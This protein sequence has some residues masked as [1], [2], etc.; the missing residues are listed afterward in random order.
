MELRHLT[1]FV[2]VAEE[3]HFGRAAERLHIAQSPLS[4]Q[5][6][7]LERDLGVR[8]FERTTRTVR[9]T[10]AGQALVEPARR[11]LADA[12]AVRRTVRA[13]HLGEAGRVT[14]GFAGASSYSALPL[15][16]RA[17]TSRLPGIELVLEGRTY[18]GEALRRIIDGTL[19]IGFV[20]LPVRRG[21]TAR[22]V[23]MERLVLALPDSHP[24][25]GRPGVPVSELADEPIVTFPLSRESAVREA[26]VQACHDAGFAPRIAQEAPDSYTMLALVG[27]GVGVAVVV[28]S[29]RDIHLEHVVFRPL[30]GDEVP[31]LPM[32]L[33]WRTGDRSA[34]LEAVLRVA[35]E[36]LPTPA[37]APDHDG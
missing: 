37:D 11:L 32:A 24:L 31:V 2:A 29:A 23:R 7:L 28:E 10:P 12:S 8:L 3:L 34:A 20:A 4:Q 19:D 26:M 33:A 9:L 5:I 6:R 21:I 36:V 16:T 30:T 13:A 27:A 35:E 18:T 22:V 1:G 17:V 15:L 25:A 14:V